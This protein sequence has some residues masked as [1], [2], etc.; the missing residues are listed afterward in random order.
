[1]ATAQT[2]TLAAQADPQHSEK[3]DTDA[4]FRRIGYR[5]P[6]DAT[7]ETLR[8]I[9][10]LHPQH[11]PFENLNPF[12][13]IPVTL[14]L[15]TLQHKLIDGGRGGY[16]FEHNLLLKSV[17]ESLG[18]KVKGLAA[19]V[20]WNVPEGI[21]TA[22]GH[23][24][25]LVETEGNSYIADV[26]FGGLTLTAPLPLQANV[27]QETPHE[28]FRFL[29]EDENFVLQA[30]IKGEWNP[31]YK[32]SLEEQFLPDYEVT[33]WYLSNYPNSHF[34]T[35]LIAA[36]STPDKRYALRNTN[37]SVHHL[38]GNTEK[39]ALN[40]ATEIKEVLTDIF[41]IRVPENHGLEQALERII[42]SERV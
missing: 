32:F 28:P 33:N 2:T 35:G 17:L 14:D 30:K 15:P 41:K 12:L 37:L 24:V 31:L 19:R 27:A 36:R 34:V 18:F 6:H 25:L 22:R 39:K 3:I 23:M 5:G 9:H 11:I 10:F 42:E 4:Y 8:N 7:L 40:S 20:R 38:D 1:M 16:C 21:V 13:R 29:K 26:G